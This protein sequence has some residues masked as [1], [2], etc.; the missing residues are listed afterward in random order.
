[1]CVL[2]CIFMHVFMLVSEHTLTPLL[3]SEVGAEDT[4]RPEQ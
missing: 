2:V 1:M 4:R 3:L